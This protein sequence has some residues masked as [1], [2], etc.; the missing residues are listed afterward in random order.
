[1]FAQVPAADKVRPPFVRNAL[2]FL[3]SCK[4][5]P[6]AWKLSYVH[7]AVFKLLAPIYRISQR[8][9]IISY[10]WSI[11][12]VLYSGLCILRSVQKCIRVHDLPF[13][14][15]AYTYICTAHPYRWKYAMNA[16]R[17]YV[18]YI[19]TGLLDGIYSFMWQL[20]F[21]SDPLSVCLCTFLFTALEHNNAS[22][23]WPRN[24][25]CCIN[26]CCNPYNFRPFF[27]RRLNTFNFFSTL[28]F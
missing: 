2:L 20:I 10:F 3:S 24:G 25:V 26:I 7:T 14:L 27:Q 21:S 6:W 22:P 8:S 9:P 11:Y 1:M 18:P 17:T 23:L 28:Y 13:H 16:T 15:H 12:S 19:Y 4:L 5:E